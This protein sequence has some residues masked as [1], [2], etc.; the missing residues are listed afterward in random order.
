MINKR[1]MKNGISLIMISGCVGIISGLFSN[2]DGGMAVISLLASL[3]GIGLGLFT[4]FCNNKITLIIT[5]EFSLVSLLTSN[6]VHGNFVKGNTFDI[7]Y[8]G[9]QYFIYIGGVVATFILKDQVNEEYP[10][11]NKALAMAKGFTLF[12]IVYAVNAIL[13]QVGLLFAGAGISIAVIALS[14]V[15]VVFGFISLRQEDNFTANYVAAGFFI[16][17]ATSMLLNLVFMSPSGRLYT[18]KIAPGIFISFGLNGL[19][20]IILAIGNIMSSNKAKNAY[21]YA[22]YFGNGAQQSQPMN[23]NVLNQPRP[24]IQPNSYQPVDNQPQPPMN[25]PQVGQTPVRPTYVNNDQQIDHQ[26]DDRNDWN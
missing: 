25:N 26:F 21:Y 2:F 6:I 22:Y 12:N 1:S 19:F 20:Y 3:I 15:I 14:I 24:I 17:S 11:L 18:N 23:P 13:Q 5:V 8:Q 9:L 7:I 4:L 10:G 16:F